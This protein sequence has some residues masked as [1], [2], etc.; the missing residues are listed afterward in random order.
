MLPA[1]KTQKQALRKSLHSVLRSLDNIKEQSRAVADKVL[2]LP[3][4]QRCTT[5][6]CYLSMPSG[7]LDTSEIVANILKS[8]TKSLFVPRISQN[9]AMELLKLYNRDDLE[10]L[11]SGTWGIR[12]PSY[13]TECGPRL[14]AMDAGLD[15]ILVPGVAFDR[16]MSRLGHGKGYYDRYISRYVESGRPRPL[17]VALALRDQLLTSIPVEAHDFKMD[18]IVTPDEI[19][20][21]R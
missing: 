11:P 18:I 6:S 20:H 3:E 19:L 2:L 9:G 17:L 14:N 21:R 5:V 15:L 7:E 10:T 16:S 8:D 4:F 1:L 12:E 13:G